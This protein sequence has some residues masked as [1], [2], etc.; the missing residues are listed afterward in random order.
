[1]A[2][3][4][5]IVDIALIHHP[6]VNKNGEI[7]GSAVTNLDLHDIA[8][9]ARTYE[10]RNYF[11]ATPFKDQ[12][13]L[14]GEITGHWHQGHGAE[15]NPVRGQALQLIKPVES[16]QQAV[17][18]ITEKDGA[19]PL[20]IATSAQQQEKTIS[21]R[22]LLKQAETNSRTVLIVFGTAHGLAQEILDEC[23]GILPPIRGNGDY[24]HLSVRSAVSII[25][26]RL[27]GN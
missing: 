4:D 12:R 26:D 6:V 15:Y 11:V 3:T 1:M 21:Y 27:L 17:E 16:L 7:I 2:L 23:D 22:E 10:V 24:N 20:V 9:A 14:I 18:R 5:C 25:L 13:A 19:L 8:R